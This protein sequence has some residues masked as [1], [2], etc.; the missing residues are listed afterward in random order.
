MV[1]LKLL[2]S[3]IHQLK[4]LRLVRI[5]H[6]PPPGL[7]QQNLRHQ[8]LP[9]RN[10]QPV[11]RIQNRKRQRHHRMQRKVNQPTVRQRHL[12]LKMHSLHPKR[13]KA[14]KQLTHKLKI[15]RLKLTKAQPRSQQRRHRMKLRVRILT[16]RQQLR[17][18]KVHKPR[19][20][21]DPPRQTRRPQTQTL[22]V[23]PP[24]IAK[25][26]RLLTPKPRLKHQIVKHKIQQRVELRAP[27]AKR[28][29]LRVRPLTVR[30]Q[31]YGLKVHKLP[32]IS[33]P[34]RPRMQTHK[35]KPPQRNRLARP[36]PLK[37]QMRP[38]HRANHSPTIHKHHRKP[39]IPQPLKI[40]LLAN[41]T[42]TKR[43]TNM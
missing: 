42:T 24:L 2:Q 39:Q 19:Q 14:V 12:R 10:R 35:V 30:Q 43:I 16:V 40:L 33:Q 21:R 7:N 18:L 23:R 3:P 1:I 20:I 41:P 34:R 11:T 36:K 26:R 9:I 31:M 37:L 17:R 32:L 38:P 4:P 15:R 25:P 29:H 27:Q 13:T 22:K 8:T 5:L 6:T 28:R